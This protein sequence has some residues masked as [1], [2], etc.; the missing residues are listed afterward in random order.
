M[1]RLFN[2]PANGG[3][4]PVRSKVIEIP[5]QN[6]NP[7]YTGDRFKGITGGLTVFLAGGKK[8]TEQHG[9]PFV[10]DCTYNYDDRLAQWY[11]DDYYNARKEAAEL[12]GSQGTGRFFELVLQTVFDDPTMELQHIVSGVNHG[13]GYPYHVYG[14]TTQKDA[15]DS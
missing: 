8:T 9:F 13:N 4:T 12:A 3:I 7:H 1:S 15:N 11:G 14:T 6:L 10:E 5:R 2:L